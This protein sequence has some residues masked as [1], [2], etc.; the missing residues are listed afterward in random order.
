MSDARPSRERTPRLDAKARDRLVAEIAR[1]E[2]E[3]EAQVTADLRVAL[4]PD[5]A[6]RPATAEGNSPPPPPSDSPTV[7]VTTAETPTGESP[8]PEVA[9]PPRAEPSPSVEEIWSGLGTWPVDP[10]VLSRN[11]VITAERTDPAHGAFD[12]L[13]T[14]LVQAI[15]SNGWSRVGITS[16]TKGCGK[17][18][19]AINLAIT[20]SRY[21]NMRTVLLDMDLR[22]PSL[23]KYLGVE[24][25]AAMGEFL[26]GN[27]PVQRLLK[28]MGPNTLNIGPNLAVGL[29]SR[30]EAYA[31]ELFHEDQTAKALAEL[32]SVM[33]PDLVLFDLPP[34]F[35][36][37]DVIAFRPHM[38]CVLM[39]V[40]GGLTTPR[41]MQ[42]TVRRLGDDM[43][44]VGVILNMA[45]GPG[46]REYAY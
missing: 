20:L 5:P 18:F 41:E 19:S 23:A 11:L 14:R 6:E 33:R 44:V 36:Q 35:A 46:T 45:E 3:A 17:S 25:V 34:A 37:D 9:A 10:V 21:D 32:Q 4:A 22:F 1:L 28:R 16:P 38:D 26:R 39:V 8:R 42:E 24:P 12:V 7:S 27:L 30:T 13:R 2:Q 29:N 31:A 43:P 40:G 15:A